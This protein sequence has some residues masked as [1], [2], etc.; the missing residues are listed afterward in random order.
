CVTFINNNIP[1][2]SVSR[3]FIL[4]AGQQ[5]SLQTDA[6]YREYGRVVTSEV[7]AQISVIQ[8]YHVQPVPGQEEEEYQVPVFGEELLA[9]AK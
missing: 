6:F 8:S 4:L 3:E 1:S 7:P 9:M 2:E 5:A